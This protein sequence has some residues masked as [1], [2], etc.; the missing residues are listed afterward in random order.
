ME[1]LPLVLLA[2]LLGG[3]SQGATG[4]GFGL[5]SMAILPAALGVRLAVPVVAGLALL[6]SV[7]VLVRWRRHL[8]VREVFPV[9]LGEAIGSP[10][11]VLGLVTIAARWVEAAL[12]AVLLA[13]GL[14]SLAGRRGSPVAAVRSPSR[15]WG[16]V[17]GTLGGVL[18]GA[19]NTGGPP[20]I[21][22]AA[23]RGWSPGSF[24]ANLQL[25]FLFNTG[26]QLVL[27]RL[28]GLFSGQVLRLEAW[29]LPA[30][31]AGLWI[32]TVLGRR[33]D[34]ERFRRLV[35]ALLVAFGAAYLV[36]SFYASATM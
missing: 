35:F 34:A 4:I 18:G 33:L 3:V 17:A 20:L 10:L 24:R 22:Y 2:I 5:V 27:L 28:N 25:C 19:F 15:A 11:G 31:A 16:T 8:V 26:I 13:Y 1:H 36:R 6:A 32:G 21:V 30:L 9:L 7:F 12:G 23:A 29:A 14:R